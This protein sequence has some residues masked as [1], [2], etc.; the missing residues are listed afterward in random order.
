M[1]LGLNGVMSRAN[2]LRLA[3]AAGIVIFT[4]IVLFSRAMNANI[5]HDEYQ[6]VAGGQLLANELMLPYLDYAYLHMPYLIGFYAILFKM[7]AYDFMA[8]RIFSA[9]C[10]TLTGLVI[11]IIAERL[12]RSWN[13]ATRLS[14]AA[15][16]V[17]LYITNPLFIS[18]DGKAWNHALPAL[19]SLVAFL[20]YFQT[21][22]RPTI[23][24]SFICGALLGVASGTRLTYSLLVPVFLAMF[25]FRPLPNDER[26]LLW[27]NLL[28]FCGGVF[29]ALIPILIL[30]ALAPRQFMYGNYV[31][32][33]LNTLYRE[34]MDFPSAMNLGGK[35]EYFVNHVLENPANTLLY[36]AV[37]IYMIIAILQYIKQRQH[38]HLDVVLV[39]AAAIFM[40]VGA[41]A[42]TPSWV[43]YF[44]APLPYL[45]L[46][47]FA[48]ISILN[49]K[50]KLLN[51]SVLALLLVAALLNETPQKISNDLSRLG[52][53][54]KWLPIQVHE[55]A[56]NLESLTPDGKILTLA[57]IFPLE[58]NLGI[59]DAFAT[60]PFTWRTAHYLSDERR[61]QYDVISYMDLEKYL[62]EEPPGAILVGFEAG[63][64]GFDPYDP[65]SLEDPFIDYAVK[66]GYTP[67]EML[68]GYTGTYVVLWV[69]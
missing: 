8:A 52:N 47:I 39:S 29:V 27:K 68:V 65:T 20:I 6:F 28:A 16:A 51:W 11:F 34:S 24:I 15:F 50:L 14:I 3:V 44:F 5:S 64:E 22:G 36:I 45:I 42:P 49:G 37:L 61:Q 31:Y 38:S 9:I 55:F 30:F 48:G 58:M 53:P 10:G 54:S 46:A 13:I 4:G 19:L 21:E 69:K 41:F 32:I 25:Y 62:M 1:A 2:L 26:R 18:I 67:V 40:L 7:T 35:I 12:L 59:Y 23:R 60:G 66:N 57:P 33:K 63:Y 17:L 56:L 43:H